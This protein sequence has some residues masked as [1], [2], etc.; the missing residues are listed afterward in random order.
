MEV[1]GNAQG[2]RLLFFL[3]AQQRGEEAEDGVGIQPLPIGQG[4]DAVIGPV[5]D[6]IAVNDHA[7]HEKTS[8]INMAQL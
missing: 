6:G 1:K 5:D 2:V 7:L 8:G 3:Q 4:T